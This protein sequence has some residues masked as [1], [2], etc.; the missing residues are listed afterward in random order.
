MRKFL[1]LFLVII[2]LTTGSAY[3]QNEIADE[4]KT[5][6]TGETKAY[7]VAVLPFSA[8][9]TTEDIVQEVP[10][11]MT[12]FMSA[13]P[14]LIMVE[15]AEIEKA[16]EEM[17]LGISGTVDPASAARIG[18]L[19]GAQVIITGRAFAVKK[20]LVV[21]AKVI[22]VE[23]G[24]VFGETTTIP[25]NGSIVTATEALSEKVANTVAI[26]GHTMIAKVEPQEDI[27]AKLKKMVEGKTLPT[28]AVKIA[29]Q[30]FMR[31]TIDPAAE[32]EISNILQQLGF[33]LLDPLTSDIPADIEI[34]G[35]AFSEFAL[36]KGNLVS[37]KARV[38]IK[39]ADRD[40]GA[41]YLVDREQAVAVDLASEIAGKTALAKAATKLVE[42]IVP[43]IVQ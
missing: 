15:R 28:I 40:S 33:K 27:V 11:L 16:L 12:A 9:K 34:N 17:E 8:T 36:R 2:L 20:D 42:R 21:V 31:E 4:H 23:T 14:S 32:T 19:T 35:E 30:S 3:A 25:L 29:E 37:V 38:E 22:G 26:N 1:S 5:A 13:N 7:S 39:V 24:R 18:Y 41:L 43:A 10:A 6:M